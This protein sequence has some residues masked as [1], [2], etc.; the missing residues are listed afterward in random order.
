MLL[1]A[2]FCCRYVDKCSS[3]C[4]FYSDKLREPYYISSFVFWCE[5]ICLYFVGNMDIAGII[6]E[7]AGIDFNIQCLL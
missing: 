1:F 2:V 5:N 3:L 4:C 6:E 7:V